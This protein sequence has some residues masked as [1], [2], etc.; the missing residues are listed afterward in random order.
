[1][2]DSDVVARKLLSLNEAL[3]E[4]QRPAAADARALAADPVLRAAVERWLQIA[5][6]ACIDI[7]FHV[8]A[9]EGW[10]PPQT[11]R[12]SFVSLAAHGR[13]PLELAQRLGAAAALRNVLVHDYAL[14]DLER[15]ARTVREDLGDLRDFAAL[16]GNWLRAT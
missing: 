16:A 15:V 14:L 11:A 8:V 7:A 2:V 3:R 12:A 1:M 4:L 10:T 9:D 5:V 13:L 6:E